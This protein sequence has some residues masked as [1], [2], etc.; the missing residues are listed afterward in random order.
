M[1]IKGKMETRQIW[2]NNIELHPEKSQK[3]YNHSPDGF[4]W[5]YGGS[6]PAQLALAILLEYYNAEIARKY[7]QDFKR[8][9]ICGLPQSDF[10]QVIGIDKW[11]SKQQEKE[12]GSKWKY[13]YQIGKLYEVDGLLLKLTAFTECKANDG[14]EICFGCPG[15]L[16]LGSGPTKIIKCGWEYSKY[17]HDYFTTYKVFN[18]EEDN[19]EYK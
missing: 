3:L 2:L 4:N 16:M 11:F 8:D 13:Y 1:R 12:L 15:K 10:E 6:G 7:Y 17:N 18:L 9:I 5:G 14:Q 19:E